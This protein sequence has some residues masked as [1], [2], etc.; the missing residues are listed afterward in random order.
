MPVTLAPMDNADF[1]TFAER[2]VAEYGDGMVAA[3]EWAQEEALQKARNVFE[4]LLPQGRLTEKNQLWVIKAQGR[5]I[6]EL[7]IAERH[8]GVGKIAFILDIYI[9]PGERRLG[10][11]KQSLQALESWARQVGCEEVR[12]HVFGR[13]GAARRLYEES[14][15]GIASL[16]MAK[17]LPPA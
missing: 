8:A 2:A 9:A 14:G 13:N 15:Y 11:A 1:V 17:P 4:Q 3:G 5:R 12:L 7:W 6:G 10:Y 16:T